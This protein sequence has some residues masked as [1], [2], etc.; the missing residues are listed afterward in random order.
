VAHRPGDRVG[1]E[2][3]PDEIGLG[4]APRDGDQPAAT[5]AGDVEN[6]TAA[7]QR[8]RELRDLGQALLEEHGDVLDGD[9]LDRAVEARRAFRDRA[10]GPE[11][12]G[13]ALVVEAGDDGDDELATEILGMGVVEENRRDVVRD[14]HARAVEAEEVA[15]VRGPD[16][17]RDRLALAAGSRGEGVGLDPVTTGGP[18]ALEQS[19]LQPEVDHP[20]A[21]EP[22]DRGRKFL[23][24]IVSAHL[25]IVASP[26]GGRS[27]VEAPKRR[28]RSGTAL[29]LGES[30]SRS[31]QAGPLD[32]FGP[33]GLRH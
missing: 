1:L 26:R 28:P 33:T 11:E 16:P 20:A 19:E 6:P 13:Q 32:E 7:G 12:L 14:R 29:R 2:L 30:A 21:V 15:G 4:E 8:R 17:V 10:A 9:R 3:D 24:S 22:A 25:G 31:G 18:D 27:G 23:E 5:T